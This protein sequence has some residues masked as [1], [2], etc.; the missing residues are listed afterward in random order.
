MQPKTKLIT[1]K[2]LKIYVTENSYNTNTMKLGL[3]ILTINLTI[4]R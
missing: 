2:C 1:I 3:Q 4:N